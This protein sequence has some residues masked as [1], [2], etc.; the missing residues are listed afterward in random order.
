MGRKAESPTIQSAEAAAAAFLRRRQGKEP[1]FHPSCSFVAPPSASI[2]MNHTK[3]EPNML[4]ELFQT[5]AFP[6]RLTVAYPNERQDRG[7]IHHCQGIRVF[8]LNFPSGNQSTEYAGVIGHVVKSLKQ[9]VHLDLTRS[10]T[11][12]CKNERLYKVN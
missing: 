12:C 5:L 6:L 7:N 3:K 1:I 4:A 11:K 10:N 8:R 9:C 2:A